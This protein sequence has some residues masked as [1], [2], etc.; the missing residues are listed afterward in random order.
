ME[1]SVRGRMN[2]RKCPRFF[3]E[4]RTGIGEKLFAFGTRGV[5]VEKHGILKRIDFDGMCKGV[6]RM[7]KKDRR[8]QIEIDQLSKNGELFRNSK[9][10]CLIGV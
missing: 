7:R 4:W 9:T 2:G 5:F 1:R 6:W 8:Q 10:S 3:S